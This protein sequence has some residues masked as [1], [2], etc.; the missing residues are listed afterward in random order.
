VTDTTDDPPPAPTAQPRERKGRLP[1]AQ[2][3]SEAGKAPRGYD[4]GVWRD[5]ELIGPCEICDKLEG[6][7]TH[8]VHNE[9]LVVCYDCKRTLIKWS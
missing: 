8:I 5:G 9:T 3:N 1:G 4:Y 7:T 2:G 6:L